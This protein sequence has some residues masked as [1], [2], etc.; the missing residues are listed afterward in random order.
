MNRDG[1]TLLEITIAT[2][3]VSLLAVLVIGFL[4]DTFVN[5]VYKS[6]ES[7]MLAEAQLALER[8]EKDIRHASN[9]DEQ[10]RWPDSNAP[11][12]NDPYSWQ[13]DE[14]TLILASPAVDSD[15]SF[16]YRDPFAYLTYKDNLIYFVENGVLYRRTL[17]ADVTGND[18]ETTCPEDD[19]TSC[20]GDIELAT[21]VN[22]F[23]LRYFDAE[24]NEV[25]PSQARSVQAT[26]QLKRKVYGRSL[27]VEYEIRSVFRNE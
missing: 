11:D 21:G 1:F 20:P 7:D 8:L 3:V 25:P 22:T 17:A 26:L 5:R 19:S 2:A 27:D 23:R 10:N 14:D 12:D 4:T 6:A 13:S 18:A 15:N 16:V 24:D 9:V